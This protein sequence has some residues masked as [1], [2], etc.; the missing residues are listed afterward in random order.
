MGDVFDF[1]KAYDAEFLLGLS[2]VSLVLLILLISV[3]RKLSKLGRRYSTKLMDGSVGEIADCLAQQAKAI[4]A[5]EGRL[6]EISA[7][8]AEQTET[9]AACV[10]KVGLVRFDAFDDVGGEQSFALVLLDGKGAGVAL[11]SLYGRQDSRL[12]AKSIANGGSER[13]LSD[14]EKAALNEAQGA[15]LLTRTR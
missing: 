14:E 1:I 10:Q 9:I 3:S 11:S 8:Q 5:I 6:E 15:D 2:V 12:Y 4:T 7:K 13:E